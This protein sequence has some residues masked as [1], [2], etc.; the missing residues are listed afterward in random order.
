MESRP[1]LTARAHIAVAAQRF[2]VVLSGEF[3]DAK[4]A[5][6]GTDRDLGAILE[7]FIGTRNLE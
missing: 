7:I 3:E 5:Y 2:D 6:L 4:V 1:I